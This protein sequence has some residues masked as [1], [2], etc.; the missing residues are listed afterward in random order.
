[1]EWVD[2]L[3][4]LFGLLTALLLV[5]MPVAFAFL[6]VN[7]VGAYLFMGGERGLPQI[8]RNMDDGLTKIALLPIPLFL[9]MGEI[10][11]Q[12]RIAERAIDAI[13]RL[14]TRMPGRLSVVAIASGTAFSAL[15][16]STIANTAM[17]GSTLMPQMLRR[18]YHPSMAMG[19]IMASGAIAMLIPPSALAVLLGA[20]ALIPIRDLLLGGIVP[21]LILAVLFVGYIML[22]GALRPQDAPAEPTRRLGLWERWGPFVTHVLPLG[23]VVFA[24]VGTLM[25]GLATPS[26]S[27]AFGCLAA[28]LLALIYRTVSWPMAGRVVRETTKLTVMILFIIAASQIFS[29]ILVF[30]QIK[31]GLEGFVTALDLGAFE[32]VLIMVLVLLVLGCFVDQVSMV[33]IT[34]PLF[35]PLAETLEIDL[36]WLGVLYLL[37]MELSLLTP[38]F[39]LLL[40]VMRGVAPE[41]TTI[42]T[43][44]RAALPFVLIKLAV[45]AL[46]LAV[47][48]VGTW[49]PA[50]LAPADE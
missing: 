40:F 20:V 22:R 27:A 45:L 14:I 25:T 24:V 41:G 6:A 12:S 16:G 47:P 1:M 42:V 31:S 5:G 7:L 38:P 30:A 4:I 44:Y 37:T 48:E 3:L 8:I 17:L 13:D 10:L 32:I 23:L 28:A 34:V 36:V 15:S 33:M 2:N 39:G 29:Q 11:L 50:V 19:P 49:L 46:L 35:V 26:T 9:L 43:V 18:G 21:A